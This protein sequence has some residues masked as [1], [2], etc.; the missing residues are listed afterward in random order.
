M[1]IEGDLGRT[2]ARLISVLTLLAVLGL[3]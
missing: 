1:K 3:L 2:V